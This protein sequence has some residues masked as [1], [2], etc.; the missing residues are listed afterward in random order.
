MK[1]KDFG[2]QYKSSN[3]GSAIDLDVNVQRDS[4][5][6]ILSGLI[7][8]PTLAQNMT[9]ILIA[10]PGDFKD[11]LSVGVGIR[12]ALLDEDMLDYRHKIKEQFPL[13]GL[14]VKHL[15]L[16]NLKTFS[17]DAEYES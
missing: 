7:L 17:I 2:I 11:N 1:R 10:E 9:C 5:G 3:D 13:D 16:Y 15:D 12:S 8:G 6:K 14:N 4:T